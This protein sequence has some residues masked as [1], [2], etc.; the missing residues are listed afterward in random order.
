[1]TLKHQSF[2][3]SSTTRPSMFPHLAPPRPTR[4]AATILVVVSTRGPKNT[5]II[6]FDLFVVVVG[7]LHI[8]ESLV[9]ISSRHNRE[10]SRVSER[11]EVMQSDD[12]FCCCPCACHSKFATTIDRKSRSDTVSRQYSHATLA[13]HINLQNMDTPH[14]DPSQGQV[15]HL[16]TSITVELGE[17]QQ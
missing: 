4:P 16:T 15:G 8:R 7:E 3:V 12:G 11:R 2:M 5:F 10:S 13:Q 14:S 17:V 9:R 6:S 1:M